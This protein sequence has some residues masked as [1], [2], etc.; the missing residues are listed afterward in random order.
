M[1]AHVASGFYYS[2]HLR[3]FK[4]S[5]HGWVSFQ[6]KS[7]FPQAAL[8]HFTQR[9]IHKY[10]THFCLSQPSAGSFRWAALLPTKSMKAEQYFRRQ[11]SPCLADKFTRCSFIYY[12][13][14]LPGSYYKDV[15]KYSVK[16]LIDSLY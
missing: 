6:P 15:E 14:L 5:F 8:R 16:L 4:N 3:S 9:Y 12:Q 2:Q 1:A 7:V 13:F 10:C 11:L